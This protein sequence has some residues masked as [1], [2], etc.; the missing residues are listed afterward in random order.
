MEVQS[1][2]VC[3]DQVSN[4]EDHLRPSDYDANNA[5]SPMSGIRINGFNPAETERK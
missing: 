2:N 3:P 5:M 1:E 4:Y